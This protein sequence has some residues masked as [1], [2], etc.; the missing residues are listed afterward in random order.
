[1]EISKYT[2]LSDRCKSSH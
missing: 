1:M 2:L